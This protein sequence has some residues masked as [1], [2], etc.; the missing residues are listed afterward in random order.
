MRL[1]QA[2][3]DVLSSQGWLAP[4]LAAMELSQLLVQAQWGRESPLRQ[5]PHFSPSLIKKCQDAKLET[6]LDILE[7]D[8]ADRYAF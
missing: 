4:A 1:L 6:V 2:C 7:M 5:I 3:V 8:D